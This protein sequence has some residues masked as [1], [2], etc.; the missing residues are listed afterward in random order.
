M[1]E[2]QE[3]RVRR[4]WWV[5]ARD[6]VGAVVLTVIWVAMFVLTALRLADTGRWWDGVFLVVVAGLGVSG[7]ASIVYWVREGRR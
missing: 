5:A 2:E 1:S 4:P 7:I 6:T 3:V